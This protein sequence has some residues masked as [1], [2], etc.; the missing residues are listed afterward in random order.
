MLMTPLL[1]VAL[2][3]NKGVQCKVRRHRTRTQS[4]HL[5]LVLSYH[6]IILPSYHPTI[7]PSYHPTIL[8]SYHPTIIPSHHHTIL[9]AYWPPNS[10][11]PATSQQS[12][13]PQT[14][15]STKLFNVHQ[16]H[17][18]SDPHSTNRQHQQSDPPS[19][20]QLSI[21]NKHPPS[22]IKYPHCLQIIAGGTLG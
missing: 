13:K 17:Q 22:N 1:R 20:I 6:P 14:A 19:T 16:A 7:L 15:K 12:T 4:C 2:L 8:P 9:P 21:T 3:I 11:A 5:I 18:Q 10:K